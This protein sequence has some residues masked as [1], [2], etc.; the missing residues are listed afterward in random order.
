MTGLPQD[1]DHLAVG[2]DQASVPPDVAQRTVHRL[3]KQLGIRCVADEKASERFLRVEHHQPSVANGRYGI[4]TQAFQEE[5]GAG[6]L[7]WPKRGL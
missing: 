5:R 6:F 2:A 1:S 7:Y 3:A 4:D